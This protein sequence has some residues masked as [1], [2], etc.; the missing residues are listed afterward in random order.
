MGEMAYDNLHQ[1]PAGAS[2]EP[3]PVA[4]MA[5]LDTFLGDLQTPDPVPGP[6]GRRWP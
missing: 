6:L 2:L 3:I 5:L 1:A 4:L